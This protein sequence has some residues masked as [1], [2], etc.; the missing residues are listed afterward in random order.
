M[1]SV[2][3]IFSLMWSC[4]IALNLKVMG[5]SFNHLKIIYIIL[6]KIITQKQLYFSFFFFWLFI[7]K[8]TAL[9]LRRGEERTRLKVCFSGFISPRWR[10][11]LFCNR[12]SDQNSEEKY[13]TVRY[14]F[15]CLNYF[16]F[17][18]YCSD[19]VVVFL[20]WYFL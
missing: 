19:C 20:G 17:F 4:P 12:R 9:E 6:C 10:D 13:G 5:G 14:D 3:F 15:S 7:N 8:I 1:W 18:Q 2:D 16:K 11:R